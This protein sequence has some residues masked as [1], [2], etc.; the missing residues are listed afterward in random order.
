MMNKSNLMIAGGLVSIVILSAL[1]H[2]DV[3]SII[4]H[5]LLA[6]AFLAIGAGILLGFINM[7]ANDKH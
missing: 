1:I 6:I 4:V 2:F 5:I 7:V 3:E